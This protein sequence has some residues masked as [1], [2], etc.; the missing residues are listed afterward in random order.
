VRFTVFPS[1][2]GRTGLA[3]EGAT[4]DVEG[5]PIGD[6]R[7][8]ERLEVSWSERGEDLPEGAMSVRSLPLI[9]RIRELVAATSAG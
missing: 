4:F 6:D 5:T 1:G 9:D 3:A 8:W 7:R 2:T